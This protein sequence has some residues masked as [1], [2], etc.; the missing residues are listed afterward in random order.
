MTCLCAT[1][2]AMATDRPYTLVASGSSDSTVVI[3]RREGMESE[4]KTSH[5]RGCHLLLYF[6]QAALKPLKPS[7]LTEVLLS[8]WTGISCQAVKVPLWFNC[9][10]LYYPATFVCIIL[11]PLLAIGGDNAQVNLLVSRD[12]QVGLDVSTTQGLCDVCKPSPNL[13]CFFYPHG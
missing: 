2:V 9:R 1:Y 11:E 8:V 4:R 7:H 13:P 10:P 5:M 6:T 12:N 3:W